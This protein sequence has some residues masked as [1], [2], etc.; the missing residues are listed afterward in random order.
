MNLPECCKN[1]CNKPK[2]GEIK[3]CWCALPSLTIISTTSTN[4]TT[5]NIS[6]NTE[7]FT[8]KVL[9]NDYQ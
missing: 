1:C 7:F 6:I 9:N 8:K 5:S 4:I 2:E 3:V